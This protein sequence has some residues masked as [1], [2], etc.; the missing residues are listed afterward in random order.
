MALGVKAYTSSRRT[1][2]QSLYFVKAYTSTKGEQ[3]SKEGK[4]TRRI[5]HGDSQIYIERQIANR[6]R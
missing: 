5:R 4:A 6:R 3:F 2:R 1:L